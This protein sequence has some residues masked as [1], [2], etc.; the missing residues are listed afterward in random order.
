MEGPCVYVL[1]ECYAST[2]QMHQV[3]F[4][5]ASDERL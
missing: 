1:F 3:I 4:C 5:V 2:F